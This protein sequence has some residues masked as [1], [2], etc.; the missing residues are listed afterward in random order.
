MEYGSQDDDLRFSIELALMD[1]PIPTT[2]RERNEI[3]RNIVAD[4][5]LKHLKMSNWKIT[6]G[7]AIPGHVAGGGGASNSKPQD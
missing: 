2:R 3:W 5:V 6:R 1:V 7:L 4:L